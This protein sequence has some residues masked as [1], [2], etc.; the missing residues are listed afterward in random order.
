M[1]N[2]RRELLTLLHRP[3]LQRMRAAK[4]V[5]EWFSRE[6]V[7]THALLE[8]I[9]AVLLHDTELKYQLLSEP[10]AKQRAGIIRDELLHLDHIVGIADRHDHKSWP[11]S[12]SWN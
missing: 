11:K 3:R 2:I 7:T 9:G 5:A 6:D 12:L 8:L 10:S 4:D 1:N